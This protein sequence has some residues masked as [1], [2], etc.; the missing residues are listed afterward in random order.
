[1][2]AFLEDQ[3]AFGEV[4]TGCG[5]NPDGGAL[6]G[7][8]N[9]KRI[10]VLEKSQT[11]GE[12]L[13]GA[14]SREDSRMVGAQDRQMVILGDLG[15]EIEY[16]FRETDENV[17]AFLAPQE[18][19]E[20]INHD[21]FDL[22]V[23]PYPIEQKGR[24]RLNAERHFCAEMKILRRRCAA[25]AQ[26]RGEARAK[27]PFVFLQADN[28][29]GSLLH[30]NRIEEGGSAGDGHGEIECERGFA[31]AARPGE[32]GEAFGQEIENGPSKREEVCGGEFGGRDE[33]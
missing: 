26:D 23:F 15:K 32:D 30:G 12:S 14:R 1:L 17:G 25:P 22:G 20:R 7:L 3:T 6:S 10:G 21:E 29:A 13:E 31:D 16:E 9:Q 18:S 5:E 4:A 28:E 27:S 8:E 19:S 2:G 33:G 24:A 11:L